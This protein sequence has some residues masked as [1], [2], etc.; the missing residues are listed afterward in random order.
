M[1]LLLGASVM[2][3]FEVIDLL[4][5]STLKK[6][7]VAH[8]KATKIEGIRSQGRKEKTTQGEKQIE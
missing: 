6:A 3:V 2:T 4:C 5:Y 1:G 8:K 7:G